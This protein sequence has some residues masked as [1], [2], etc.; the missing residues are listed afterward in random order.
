MRQSHNK[1]IADY[2]MCNSVRDCYTTIF[3]ALVFL[4]SQ[5]LSGWWY[6]TDVCSANT[7]MVVQDDATSG[8]C[9]GAPALYRF[10]ANQSVVAIIKW[11][12]F[13]FVIVFL[14][15]WWRLFLFCTGTVHVGQLG[16]WV[17]CHTIPYQGAKI[18]ISRARAIGAQPQKITSDSMCTASPAAHNLVSVAMIC[19]SPD[20]L[21]SGQG[22][23]YHV[24]Q[25]QSVFVFSANPL[26]ILVWSTVALCD[27]VFARCSLLATSF[28]C[29]L[30]ACRT[31]V[32]SMTPRRGVAS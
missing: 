8:W 13:V 19:T 17:P 14:F 29:L 6:E 1:T 22:I 30:W 2:L 18:S 25:Q 4:P 28:V 7:R 9:S 15:W 12:V 31:L 27:S 20:A 24:F 5:W 3:T 10:S 16:S 21:H 26:S 32:R 23:A 11:N